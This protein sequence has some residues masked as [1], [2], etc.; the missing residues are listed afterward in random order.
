[1]LLVY[2]YKVVYFFK[3]SVAKET[4][5]LLDRILVVEKGFTQYAKVKTSDVVGVPFN[6]ESKYTGKKL[7]IVDPAKDPKEVPINSNKKSESTVENVQSLSK[8][9]Q[10]DDFISMPKKYASVKEKIAKIAN[11]DKEI[12]KIELSDKDKQ[13]LRDL[14]LEHEK[15][16]QLKALSKDEKKNEEEKETQKNVNV[17][18]QENSENSANSAKTNIKPSVKP[19]QMV[20][21]F[22]FFLIFIYNLM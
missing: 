7:K 11:L 18:T 5:E 14:E 3:E 22:L 17:K 13:I 21:T 2:I 6:Y 1:M 16:I 10:K 20:R 4:K 15:K 19:K 8:V 9:E 12:P